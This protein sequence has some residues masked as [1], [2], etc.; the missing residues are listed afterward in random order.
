LYYHVVV[1]KPS[2]QKMKPLRIVLLTAVITLSILFGV[3]SSCTKDA[4]KGVTCLNTGTCSGG[5][6][7]CPTGVGGN[8]CEVVYRNLYVNTYEGNAVAD[9]LFADSVANVKVA[10]AYNNSKLSFDTTGTT[11]LVNMNMQLQDSLG[12][13]NMTF[14]ITL[15]NQTTSGSTFSIEPVEING[16][17]YS[18]NG[19]LSASLATLSLTAVADTSLHATHDS[20]ITITYSCPNYI[21][22]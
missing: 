13:L 1:P 5:A 6:C 22:K 8:N 7:Q 21:V 10:V 18:G 4:C 2:D 9:T 16:F 15:A 11:S 3:Y 17:H 14:S 20:A 19:T 12:F